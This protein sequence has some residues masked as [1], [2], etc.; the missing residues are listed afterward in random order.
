MRSCTN[1]NYHNKLAFDYICH[2][3]ISKTLQTQLVITAPQIAFRERGSVRSSICYAGNHEGQLQC[4]LVQI[5][6]SRALDGKLKPL[7]MMPRGNTLLTSQL[8]EEIYSQYITPS[9]Y[10]WGMGGMNYSL[11]RQLIRF[12]SSLLVGEKQTVASV[13]LPPPP[14]HT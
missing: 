3:R 9:S 6:G 7:S 12:P 4:K 10:C 13:Q 8:G 5:E 11:R 14:P 1:N 2:L